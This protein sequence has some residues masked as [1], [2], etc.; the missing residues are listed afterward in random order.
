MKGGGG[1]RM[2]RAYS[3]LLSLIKNESFN[4]FLDPRVSSEFLPKSVQ[5]RNNRSTTYANLVLMVIL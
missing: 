3:A 2:S 5:G 1:E 4:D